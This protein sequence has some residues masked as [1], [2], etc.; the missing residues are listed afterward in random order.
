MSKPQSSKLK[1]YLYNASAPFDD[2]KD[3]SNLPALG[4]LF[5]A[6][7]CWA[8]A[9][10]C[11]LPIFAEFLDRDILTYTVLGI[12]L[13]GLVSIALGHKARAKA[14]RG[15][16]GGGTALFGLVLG[17]PLVL[18]VTVLMVSFVFLMDMTKDYWLVV[19]KVVGVKLV[20]DGGS[21]DGQQ[22][23]TAPAAPPKPAVAA[24]PPAVSS[25]VEVGGAEGALL[26]AQGKVEERLAAGQELNQI[27]EAIIL[28]PEQQGFWQNVNIMQG[29]ITA[30]PVGGNDALVMLS[31]KNSGKLVWVCGGYIPDSVK[32]ICKE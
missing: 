5:F 15:A 25:N 18:S 14:A 2:P 4:S 3:R 16:Y 30:T 22:N 31:M 10:L 19:E 13:L 9:A 27:T 20:D 23:E 11:F 7:L 8:A 24:A 29:T 26:A 12:L 17:Y 32:S 6:V 1:N 21:P 28:T